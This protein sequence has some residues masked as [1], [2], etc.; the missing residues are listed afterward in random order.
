MVLGNQDSLE[1]S[2]EETKLKTPEGRSGLSGTFANIGEVLKF[3]ESIASSSSP[4]F[5]ALAL[6]KKDR[7]TP[8]R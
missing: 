1:L 4:N 6:L 3:R 2:A 8:Q 7:L 5:A